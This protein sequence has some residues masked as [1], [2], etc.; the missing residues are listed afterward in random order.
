VLVDMLP[1][2]T[3]FKFEE[4]AEGLVLHPVVL[5]YQ[6]VM[7]FPTKSAPVVLAEHMLLMVMLVFSMRLQSECPGA[8]MVVLEIKPVK[9]VRL[10]VILMQVEP[11]VDIMEVVAEVPVLM[12]LM[13]MDISHPG[14]AVPE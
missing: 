9:M 1:P 5:P 11:V 7:L 13:A 8:P 4:E 10:A 2:P 12:A 3:I 6:P 14:V